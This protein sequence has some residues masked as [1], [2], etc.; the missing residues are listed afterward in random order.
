MLHFPNVNSADLYFRREA[1]EF[2]MSA[3]I[4]CKV[5]RPK[6]YGF[7]GVGVNLFD[8]KNGHFVISVIFLDRKICCAVTAFTIANICTALNFFFFGGC[9]R[10][11]ER[12]RFADP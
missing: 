9:K 4:L 2:G 3:A 11:V 12:E 5:N 1:W 7:K 10:K 8:G 6:F